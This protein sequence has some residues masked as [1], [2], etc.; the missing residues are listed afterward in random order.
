[1]PA[2]ER[3]SPE[4]DVITDGRQRT[5]A[6]LI[7]HDLRVDAETP[8]SRVI[9]LFEKNPDF[10]AVAVVG[11]RHPQIVSR[12]RFFRELG[13]R[14]GFALLEKQPV[15]AIAE[16]GSTAEAG[17]DPVEV[18]A[19]ALERDT[20]RIYDDILVVEGAEVRGLV[21]F[22]ALMSHHKEL[23]LRSMAERSVLEDKARGLEEINRMQSEF[24]SNMTHELRTPV[25]TILGVVE[26]IRGEEN[27]TPALSKHITVLSTR[28][29]ELGGIVNNILDRHRLDAGAMLPDCDEVDVF[30]LLHEMVDAFEPLAVA[31]GLSLQINF[32]A[33]VR[34]PFPTDSAFVRRILTNL[35]SNAIKFTQYGRVTLEASRTPDVLQ[36]SVSDTGIGIAS[37]DLGRLFTRF[38]QLDATR[39]KRHAGT[40]LGLSIVKGLVE[41]L[42]GHVD[43]K[44]E[45]GQGTAFTVLL[46]AARIGYAIR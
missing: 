8:V 3:I 44:S 32:A 43:V 38:G 21:S 14:F 2:A 35:L 18:V 40:G 39:A 45:P 42:D 22:R 36:V 5:I 11:G 7:T 19:L 12:P 23:L 33:S 17:A 20:S 41:Q 4:P 27:L 26:L 13:K 34:D 6:K 25:N 24:M 16:D 31:K 10:D 37:E 29:R 15:A 46:P 28:A 1:M 30:G 9:K